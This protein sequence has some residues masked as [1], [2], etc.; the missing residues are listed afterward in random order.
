MD[1]ALFGAIFQYLATVIFGLTRLL[2]SAFGS[3]LLLKFKRKHLFVTSA[4]LTGH[5]RFVSKD[6]LKGAAGFKFNLGYSYIRTA[7]IWL[8]AQEK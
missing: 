6:H 2:A 8:G 5:F 7:R 1:W 4:L 3:G